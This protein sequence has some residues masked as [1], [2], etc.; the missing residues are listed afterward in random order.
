MAGV[1]AGVGADNAAPGR[2]DSGAGRRPRSSGSNAG[3]AGEF[4]ARLKLLPGSCASA[5]ANGE[6]KPV[7][8]ASPRLAAY[9][10]GTKTGR[11]AS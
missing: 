11:R 4:R 1:A 5:R 3:K 9:Q 8:L 2:R 10:I 6:A 7:G